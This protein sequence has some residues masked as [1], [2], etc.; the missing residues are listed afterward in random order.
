MKE[1]KIRCPI[2]R[3]W[4]SWDDDN[5]AELYDPKDE[6]EYEDAVVL[7]CDNCWTEV[8]V[9]EKRFKEVNK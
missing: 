2:C 6:R 4:L 3:N 9:T 1:T 7:K 8:M 5:S